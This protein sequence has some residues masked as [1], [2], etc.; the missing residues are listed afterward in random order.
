MIVAKLFWLILFHIVGGFRIWVVFM[1]VP[2]F[3]SEIVL[4]HTCDRM[5]LLYQLI[6]TISI[7][8]AYFSNAHLLK[9]S[10]QLVF[11]RWLPCNIVKDT[12]YS[13][14]NIGSLHN[15]LFRSV[16]TCNLEIKQLETCRNFLGICYSLDTGF[17]NHLVI[18]TG[19]K[20]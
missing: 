17:I 11:N 3:I 14:I 20:R 16:N 10:Q 15:L 7:T 4:L 19:N 1:V 5:V 8:A 12:W 6:I 13:I 9:I 2:L 18:N